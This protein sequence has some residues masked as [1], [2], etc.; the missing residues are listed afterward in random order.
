[1]AKE[2]RQQ[3][4]DK[5]PKKPV[6]S[7]QGAP[8]G[9]LIRNFIIIGVLTVVFFSIYQLNA[10]YAELR[11][12]FYEKQAIENN[13]NGNAQRLDEINHRVHDIKTDTGYVKML[14]FGYFY[15][16]HN[17]AFGEGEQIERAITDIKE[18]KAKFGLDNTGPITRED[19]LANKVHTFRLLDFVN[20]N[21][22]PNSVILLPPADSLAG[23]PNWY[24]IYDPIWV[25][26]FIYPRL[27]IETG[28]EAEYPALAKRITHVLIVKGIGYDKLHYD[29]P[30][31]KR[32]P[33]CLLP[34]N[35]PADANKTS[36]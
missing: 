22:P 6:N 26:Y 28:H 9:S 15:D 1:V 21:C 12:L 10:S 4:T 32:E 5:T 27:C 23:N 13:P 25:E 34:I 36:N 11:D 33:L 20:T 19:K 30:A 31:D 2:K 18:D 17:V 35:K 7:V 8:G 24:Y 3:P 16:V 29:V 14:F